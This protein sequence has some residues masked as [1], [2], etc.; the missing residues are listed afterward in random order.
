[1][2]AELPAS[3]SSSVAL[4]F[5]AP[6]SQFPPSYVTLPAIDLFLY[7]IE[8]NYELRSFLPTDTRQN[9]GTI[10][11]QQRQPK[12]DCHYMISAFPAKGVLNPDDDEH[13]MLGEALRVLMR[14]RRLPDQILQGGMVGQQT[15]VR[16]IA[17]TTSVSTG[18]KPGI[19]I[20]QALQVRPRVTI[21]Y[22]LTISVDL[23]M[24]AMIE[25]PATDVQ[26]VGG[27]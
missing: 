5:A 1:L 7:A 14:H 12:V 24:P 26:L 20:W 16:S 8:E 21:H 11:R 23:A 2:K 17:L 25:T 27:P 3:I 10:S 13:R 18:L 6:D 9:D 4:T 19:D 22:W 15:Q